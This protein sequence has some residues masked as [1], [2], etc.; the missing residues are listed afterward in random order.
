[1]TLQRRD[2]I[3][4][5][6]L[7]LSAAAILPVEEP[8]KRIFALGMWKQ[9]MHWYTTIEQGEHNAW[10]YWRMFEKGTQPKNFVA[11]IDRGRGY[12]QSTHT[13]AQLSFNNN[14]TRSF[15]VFRQ[16]GDDTKPRVHHYPHLTDK[17]TR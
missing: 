16:Y 5:G 1:M 4:S 11:A 8:I 17:Y 12:Y 10:V 2:F 9:P 3:R 6:A 15:D 13:A 14:P 7:W